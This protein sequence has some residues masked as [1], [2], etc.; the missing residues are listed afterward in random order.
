MYENIELAV[1][2]CWEDRALLKQDEYADAVRET[3]AL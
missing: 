1:E 2:K 3:V